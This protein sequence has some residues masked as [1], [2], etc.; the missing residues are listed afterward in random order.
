MTTQP[1][2][3]LLNFGRVAIWLG[4][5]GYGVFLVGVNTYGN[6]QTNQQIKAA[7]SNLAKQQTQIELAKLALIYY[8]SPDYQDVEARTHLN[9]KGPDEKVIALP[10]ATSQ[11]NLDLSAPTSSPAASTP[12]ANNSIPTQWWNLFFG[13]N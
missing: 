5:F 11:P 1:N 10:Q 12:T 2:K 7:Q 9:L 8:Q 4:L 6:Y 13:A 3:F